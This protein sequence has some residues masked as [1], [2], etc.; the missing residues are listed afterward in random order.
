[1]QKRKRRLV[2]LWSIVGVPVVIWYGEWATTSEVSTAATESGSGPFIIDPDEVP[3]SEETDQYLGIMQTNW[4]G[5]P[6][7]GPGR[8][9]T[10]VWFSL[11]WE[12]IIR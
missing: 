1:M 5:A 10:T 4:L 11:S 6:A 9:S 2:L 12:P 3:N 7:A 8:R